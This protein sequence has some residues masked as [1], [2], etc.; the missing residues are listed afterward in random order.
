MAPKEAVGRAS[1]IV[2]SIAYTGGLLGPWMA[3]HI[4][5]VAGILDL[6]LAILLGMAIARV[7]MAIMIS[8]TGSRAK[9]QK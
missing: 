2:I 9:L 3:G 1:G 4:V 6:A 8:E 7:S 5:D